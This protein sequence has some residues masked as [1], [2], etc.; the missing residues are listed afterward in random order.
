MYLKQGNA[1]CETT[2]KKNKIIYY[3]YYN[4]YTYTSTVYIF[5]QFV[6]P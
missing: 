1:I 5:K 3:Y 4:N 6:P 2:K